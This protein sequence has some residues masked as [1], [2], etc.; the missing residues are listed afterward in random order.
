M[1]EYII[2]YQ[3][4]IRG[5]FVALGLCL[6]EIVHAPRPQL[7]KRVGFH[8][9]ALDTCTTQ[10][11][12][13]ASVPLLICQT[14]LSLATMAVDKV[15]EIGIDAVTMVLMAFP[16]MREA[17]FGVFSQRHPDKRNQ[18]LSKLEVLYFKAIWLFH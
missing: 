14:P 6:S 3:G 8:V 10:N 11:G 1:K 4:F 5:A 2:Q 18:N 9:V 16:A 7:H 17:S 13:T 15:K 12:V